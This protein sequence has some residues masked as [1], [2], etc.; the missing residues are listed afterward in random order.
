M[1]KTNKRFSLFDFCKRK[2]DKVQIYGKETLDEEGNLI[3]S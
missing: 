1:T 2:A 3:R